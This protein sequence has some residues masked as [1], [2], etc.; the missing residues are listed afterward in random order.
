[1]GWPQALPAMGWVAG[2]WV[3]AGQAQCRLRGRRA[4]RAAGGCSPDPQPARSRAPWFHP[5]TAAVMEPSPAPGRRRWR[6]PQGGTRVLGPGGP[7]LSSTSKVRAAEIRA[8]TPPLLSGGRTPTPTPARSGG[9]T[10]WMKT[11]S[12]GTTTWTWPES[13]TMHPSSDQVSPGGPA[14]GHQACRSRVLAAAGP[15]GQ[16]RP[17]GGPHGCCVCRVP[18]D[19]GPAGAPRQGLAPAGPVP[20]AGVRRARRPPSPLPGAGRVRPAGR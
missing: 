20:L 1:L 15:A 4:S 6:R 19:A 3:G 11:Q 16:T 12:G 13:R 2:P 10:A 9:P 7:C 5:P 18:P 17:R 8:I 14:P